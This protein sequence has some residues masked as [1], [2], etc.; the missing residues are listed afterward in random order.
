MITTACKE[1]EN[2]R[3]KDFIYC[4]G[5]V[6]GKSLRVLVFVYGD[7]YAASRKIYERVRGKVTEGLQ[8]LELELS[9]TN[10]LGRVNRV[11]PLGITNLRVRGMWTIQNPIKVFSDIFP[12][13]FD[14]S[15]LTA[16]ALMRRAKFDSFN[17]HEKKIMESNKKFEISDVRIREPDNPAKLT[18]A[19]LIV[20]RF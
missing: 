11:D 1:C 12:K 10:E 18:D 9:E 17:L 19:K 7:C 20:L 4:I 15:K 5:L 14:K 13:N 16:I 8:T 2:W 3:E 6:E